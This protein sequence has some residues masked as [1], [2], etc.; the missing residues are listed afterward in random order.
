M[1]D[2]QKELL[3]EIG[4]DE[5][6]AHHGVKGMKWGVRKKDI[7]KPDW[8]EVF[9][10]RDLKWQRKLGK[11]KRAQAKVEKE[12]AG[13]DRKVSKSAYKLNR[14]KIKKLSD[15]EL[16]E[17]INRLQNEKKLRELVESEVKPGRTAV[18]KILKGSALAVLGTVATAGLTYAL[19]TAS[20]GFVTTPE[21]KTVYSKEA[22]K[23]AFSLKDLMTSLFKDK[24]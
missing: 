13:K 9:T 22:V 4:Y 12:Q 15:A 6:L 11:K 20:K 19:K 5:S 3:T 16:N 17:R 21:G 1:T 10:T 18:A 24:K 23:K 14:F 8:K 7:P 2:K